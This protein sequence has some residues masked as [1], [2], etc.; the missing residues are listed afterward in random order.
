MQRRWTKQIAGLETLSYLERL[1][2]LSLYSIAGRLLRADLIKLWKIFHGNVSEELL[3]QLDRQYHVST[4][5][6]DYKLAI[7]RCRT[8]TRRRFFDVRLV[9][10]WNGL[11][12]DAVGLQSLIAFKSY[13]DQHRTLDFYFYY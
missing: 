11:S 7:P 5:G 1:K 10:I 8:D 6:H 13:L 2:K 3:E 4:R 12:A 9:H